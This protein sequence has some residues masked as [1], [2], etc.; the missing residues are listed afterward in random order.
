MLN[1]YRG[2]TGVCVDVCV[3]HSNRIG[4]VLVLYRLKETAAQGPSKG[5]V[6]TLGDPAA[7]HC[8]RRGREGV[9]GPKQVK[10]G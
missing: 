2:N 3:G 6:W 1:A 8:N 9:R 10:C 7:P 4:T 5:L